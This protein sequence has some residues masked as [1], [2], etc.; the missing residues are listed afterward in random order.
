MSGSD[1]AIFNQPA[2]SSGR[3]SEAPAGQGPLHRRRD[4][5]Q[6][7]LCRLPALAPRP[8]RNPPHRHERRFADAGRA[9]DPHGRG[10]RRRRARRRAR[11][12]A[13]QAPRRLADVPP[14]AARPDARPRAPRGP[15][16]GGGDR[17]V[18]HRGEG[19]GREDRDRLRAVADHLVHG[20]GERA[21]RA[22]DLG[23][24][25]QQRA[26]LWLE[27]QQGRGG[28]GLRIRAACGARPF[29]GEPRRGDDHGDARRQRRVRCRAR[30]LH[31]LRLPSAPLRVAHDDGEVRLQ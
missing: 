6:S 5:R 25:S 2:G 21:R 11:P 31:D 10:L 26:G 8:C 24:M 9:R 13:G 16:R 3:G 22:G 29:R 18:G 1:D 12:F 28:K 23:A 7:G 4:P 14:A 27:G 30:P 15:A 17:R 20:A 19:R